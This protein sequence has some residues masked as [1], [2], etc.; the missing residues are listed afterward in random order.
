MPTPAPRLREALLR[1]TQ[2]SALQREP[3]DTFALRLVLLRLALCTADPDLAAIAKDLDTAGI[4]L[5]TFD[6]ALTVLHH[7]QGALGMGRDE[8]LEL[9]SLLEHTEAADIIDALQKRH[10]NATS[11]SPLTRIRATLE[12]SLGVLPRASLLCQV[13]LVLYNAELDRATLLQDVLTRANVRNIAD[14]TLELLS[15][16]VTGQSAEHVRTDLVLVLT[17][18]WVADPSAFVFLHEQHL[19]LHTMSLDDE[20]AL[21]GAHS[22]PSLFLLRR[23]HANDRHTEPVHKTSR[24]HDFPVEP[25]AWRDLSSGQ[26]LVLLFLGIVHEHLEAARLAQLVR[27][28]TPR[29]DVV[30]AGYK[31]HTSQHPRV[32]A[33]LQMFWARMGTA[34]DSGNAQIAALLAKFRVQVCVDI[35]GESV[36]AALT[37]GVVLQ[38]YLLCYVSRTFRGKL[39]HAIAS[40]HNARTAHGLAAVQGL[41]EALPRLLDDKLLA[42]RE[43]NKLDVVVCEVLCPRI[44]A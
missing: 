34:V 15:C 29:L 8:W 20:V 23:V 38:L 37:L 21:R 32:V 26:Q 42:W 43:A 14:V 3:R 33:A 9:F 12:Q 41:P 7:R 40:T 30:L 4:P 6:T 11:A 44:T 25:S 17:H 19:S 13:F 35:F 24:P 36:V 31:P 39:Y 18:T 27:L 5:L 16:A 1:F 2:T 10:S 22:R 28:A